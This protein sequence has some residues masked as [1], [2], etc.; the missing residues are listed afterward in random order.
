MVDAGTTGWANRVTIQL[1]CMSMW[2][3]VVM[4][5]HGS[6]ILTTVGERPLC[7]SFPE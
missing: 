1:S 7:A 6:G 3:H 5:P 2:Q 4:K